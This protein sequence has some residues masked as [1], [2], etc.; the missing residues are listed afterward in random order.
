MIQCTYI[1]AF[2]LV[3]LGLF[4]PTTLSS[5]SSMGESRLFNSAFIDSFLDLPQTRAQL[6]GKLHTLHLV[7]HYPLTTVCLTTSQAWH[8]SLP[9]LQEYRLFNACDINVYMWSTFHRGVHTQIRQLIP[10][11]FGLKC[12]FIWR[13]W[14]LLHSTST[15][16]CMLKSNNWFPTDETTSVPSSEDFVLPSSLQL[17]DLAQSEDA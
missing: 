2:I 15:G 17:G 6:L 12:T 5:S 4:P 14:K 11:S 7:W 3:I 8:L 10:N 1:S 16:I 13:L 9:L